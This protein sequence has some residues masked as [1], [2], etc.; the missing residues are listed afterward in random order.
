MVKKHYSLWPF[1]ITKQISLVPLSLLLLS[2]R[3]LHCLKICKVILGIS[4]N[5]NVLNF[6]ACF[7]WLI[8][9]VFNVQN[10][11]FYYHSYVYLFYLI[12]IC[13]NSIII[14]DLIL[15]I[16]ILILLYFSK[17]DTPLILNDFDLILFFFWLTLFFEGLKLRKIFY[18]FLI[19]V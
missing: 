10:N 19:I 16:T 5:L 4:S 17:F 18:T 8:L 7:I 11:L 9:W 3:V 2:G 1:F 15:Q 6:I 14:T 13:R 12:C